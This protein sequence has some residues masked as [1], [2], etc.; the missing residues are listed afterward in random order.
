MYLK[1]IICG[2]RMKSRVF[3]IAIVLLIAFTFNAK[4]ET[5][6]EILSERITE[7]KLNE[8]EQYGI[9]AK[10]ST[11][12][13]FSEKSN[14]KSGTNKKSVRKFV[15]KTNKINIFNAKKK[16]LETAVNFPIRLAVVKTNKSVYT[17][18]NSLVYLN[19]SK[20]GKD[21]IDEKLSN[22]VSNN[23]WKCLLIKL[24]NDREVYLWYEPSEMP[25][26]TE[27]KTEPS[28]D[29]PISVSE[30]ITEMNIFPNPTR[31]GLTV[32]KLKCSEERKVSINVYDVSG[33]KVLTVIQDE[34]LS[35]GE[36][37]FNINGEN[38]ADGIYFVIIT[39]EKGENYNL[40]LIKTNY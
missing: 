21:R 5:G 35:S 6:T 1:I 27:K 39:D 16:E 25:N 31:N 24:E 36:H 12:E 37:K 26:N 10:K 33:A 2:V 20:S 30:M 15:I 14:S 28:G 32:L 9:S 8:L 18:F 4:A 19:S 11:I 23:D 29:K 13:F 22:E 3:I 34:R 17:Y 38:L 7:V 40:K